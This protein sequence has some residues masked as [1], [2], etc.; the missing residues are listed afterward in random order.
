ML[1]EPEHHVH[2]VLHVDEVALLAAVGVVG[3]VRPEE[4]DRLPARRGGIG[5]RHAAHHPAF[6]VLVGPVDVEEL[7]AHPLRG[8]RRA[9]GDLTGD[10]AV[11]G[12][13]APPVRV[14][15]HQARQR[16]EGAV[17]V[18]AGRAV[19]VRGRGRRVDQRNG[20]L[21][22]PPP[23]PLGEADVRLRDQVRVRLGGRRDRTHV[24]HVRDVVHAA[25]QQ[26]VEAVGVDQLVELPT[27]E[28]LPFVVVAE[29]VHDGHGALARFLQAGDEV[30]A[31]EAGSSG[32][33]D[34]RAPFAWFPVLSGADRS[35]PPERV[36]RP[37]GTVPGPYASLMR[38]TAA[39]R[40]DSHVQIRRALFRLPDE[41]PDRLQRPAS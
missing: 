15:R 8:R 33:D 7:Q 40:R 27:A 35:L 22:A 12:V 23:D 5:A 31:D 11:E 13:L 32:D 18:E 2:A 14:H 21:G 6:V 4:R 10:P 28:V 37:G 17:V 20:V 3:M 36:R 29:P 41:R 34:H 1:Q 30:R 24:H 19:A 38:G 9:V 39:P 16:L 26:V 25:L